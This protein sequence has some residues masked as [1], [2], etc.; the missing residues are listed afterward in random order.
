[1]S[2]KPI[3]AFA[4]AIATYSCAPTMKVNKTSINPE[5]SD[6]YQDKLES[7]STLIG[8]GY[9]FTTEKLND[10]TYVYKQYLP[11]EKQIIKQATYKE[12]EMYNLHGK[13]TRWLDN[14][15]IY[16]TGAYLDN[17][18]TGVW[19]VY[20]VQN[21]LLNA[22]GNYNNGLKSGVWVYNDTTGR[23]RGEFTFKNG[24]LDGP[25]EILGETGEV[26]QEGELGDVQS[27]YVTRDPLFV[28]ESNEPAHLKK[29]NGADAPLKCTITELLRVYSSNISYPAKAKKMWIEGTALVSFIVNKKGEV[30]SLKV[31]R[32]LCAS[33]RK[34]LEIS[35][36]SMPEWEPAK[37]NDEPV[38]QDFLL[39]VR[40][41]IR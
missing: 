4:L 41:R 6:K 35:V 34:E 19:E 30:E 22:K 9:H 24:E 10:T 11:D 1:M 3:L 39:P 32:S 25:Y 16:E 15:E 29:C 14:G 36:A 8:A 37:S 31:R 2:I 5:Y 26:I 18:K 33:I 28:R 13:Y 27:E 17:K 21:G 7:G 40:F 20:H 23:K 12:K 38:E